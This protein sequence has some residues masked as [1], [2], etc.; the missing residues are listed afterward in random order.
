M[1]AHILDTARTSSLFEIIHVST[2]SPRVA[3]L[4]ESL[5]FE[6]HFPRPHDLA[7]D[8]TPLMP[9]LRYVTAAFKARN[10]E[11]DEVWLLMAC[12]PM[13]D[14]NDLRAAARLLAATKH[15]KAVLAVAPYPAPIEWAYSRGD[16]G[17]LF[18]V[19]SGKFAVRSQDFGL[20]F[21]DA[22]TFCA[23][24][25]RQVLQS[26]GAGDDAGFVGYVLPRQKAVDIDTEEDWRFAEIL[27][28]AAKRP[29]ESAS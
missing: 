19:S 13:I 9:V 3:S 15:T 12:A 28:A 24:P 22:G 6:V 29:R 17:S 27:F 7:D 5:G 1:I 21:Y 8:A 2:E 23:F 25:A 11:F 10:Q 20:K 18:P 26:T 14:A 4:V 16:D